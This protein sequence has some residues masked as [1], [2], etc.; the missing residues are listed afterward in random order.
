MK[1]KHESDFDIFCREYPDL[2]PNLSREDAFDVAQAEDAE[3]LRIEAYEAQIEAE[4]RAEIYEQEIEIA[5]A[6]DRQFHPEFQPPIGKNPY[7]ESPKDDEE[8]EE[9][10][11]EYHG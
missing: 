1:L 7:D 11:E 2:W 5:E 3:R 10:R 8:E 9:E 6:L 4:E